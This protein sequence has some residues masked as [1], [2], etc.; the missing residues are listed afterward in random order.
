MESGATLGSVTPYGDTTRQDPRSWSFSLVG[1]AIV[2]ATVASGLVDQIATPYLH[3]DDL[4]FLLPQGTPFTVDMLEKMH[5]EGRW[6]NYLWYQASQHLSIWQGY[7]ACFAGIVALTLALCRI[8]G[9]G[10]IAAAFAFAFILSNPLLDISLWGTTSAPAIWIAAAAVWALTQSRRPAVIVLL[11]VPA[12][13]L[14]YPPASQLVMFGFLLHSAHA[15]RRTLIEG[16][17]AYIAGYALGVLA[18]H[19]INLAVFGDFG[20]AIA[21]WRKPNPLHGLDDLAQNLATLG[22]ALWRAIEAFTGMLALGAAGLALGL[23]HGATRRP[24]LLLA[25]MVA[26]FLGIEAAL[27]SLTGTASDPRAYLW[28]WPASLGWWVIVAHGHGWW[29]S[30]A[31]VAFVAAGAYSVSLAAPMLR[32]G[33]DALRFEDRM[34][35]AA[36][37]MTGTASPMMVIYGQ[38]R[39]LLPALDEND[40]LHNYVAK[41]YGIHAANC[42]PVDCASIEARM[43]AGETS[44]M[45][46]NG[47]VAFAFPR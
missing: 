14:T 22:A 31:A 2:A 21:D 46:I 40:Q 47:A 18:I 34:V 43:A 27:T 44:P 36:Q 8:V 13:L 26:L 10:W 42:S 6:L 15:P 12:L 23:S 38:P 28:L 37:L 1:L 7:G 20:V 9:G 4:D 32:E 29:R 5:A 25:A 30:V 35:H 17:A 24:A 11:S 39:Q 45:M 19:L 3:H 41:R 16:F 33:Q